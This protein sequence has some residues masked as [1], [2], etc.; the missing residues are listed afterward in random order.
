[1]CIGNEPT[2]R[3]LPRPESARRL[4]E[5]QQ[6]I[7]TVPGT[8]PPTTSTATSL[9]PAS[10]SS[11]SYSLKYI[12]RHSR[13]TSH[14]LEPMPSV[15]TSSV[16]S[17]SALILPRSASSKPSS[18][19]TLTPASST[20]SGSPSRRK[21]SGASSTCKNVVGDDFGRR[22]ILYSKYYSGTGYVKNID[23][24][25]NGGSAPVYSYAS[26]HFFFPNHY[27]NQPE[28]QDRSLRSPNLFLPL[29]SVFKFSKTL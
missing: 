18:A 13:H 3:C 14:S 2:V 12:N 28:K 17:T 8:T 9:L 16:S 10:S 22:P 1:M 24:P 27:P 7:I 11:S 19:L 20:S 23:N 25:G 26:F 29:N 6:A 5:S 21:S 4:T 15:S